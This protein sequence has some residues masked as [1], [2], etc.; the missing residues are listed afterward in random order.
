MG[1]LS[2]L[3]QAWIMDDKRAC[4]GRAPHPKAQAKED[5]AGV[6]QGNLLEKPCRPE[7]LRIP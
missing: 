2:A 7:A 6:K 4:C 3:A 1:D 5:T